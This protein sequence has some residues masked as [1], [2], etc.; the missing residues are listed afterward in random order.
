MLS[1]SFQFKTDGD[2]VTRQSYVITTH[3][4]NTMPQLAGWHHIKK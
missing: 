1:P 3:Y 4:G 2:S